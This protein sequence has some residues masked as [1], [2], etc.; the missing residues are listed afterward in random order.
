[1]KVY[2]ILTLILPIIQ[3]LHAEGY[4]SFGQYQRDEPE[5]CVECE[6]GLGL[7]KDVQAAVATM[8]KEK[9]VTK[10]EV[11]RAS[12]KLQGL[13]VVTQDV[14]DK[15]KSNEDCP[16]LANY[17]LVMP[18]SSAIDQKR[19][20]MTK[21]IPLINLDSMGVSTSYGSRTYYKGHDGQK[22]ILV[23]VI[24]KNDGKA[25]V[26]YYNFPHDQLTEKYKLPDLGSSYQREKKKGDF[27]LPTFNEKMEVFDGKVKASG[28]ISLKKAE[29]HI[30]TEVPALNGSGKVAVDKTGTPTLSLDHKKEFYTIHYDQVYHQ[31][32]T[33]D[34]S[35][36]TLTSPKSSSSVTYT[37]EGI[38]P[39]EVNFKQEMSFFESDIALTADVKMDKESPYYK[40]GVEIKRQG[41]RLISASVDSNDKF[42]VNIPTRFTI[43]QADDLV[44]KGDNS[45]S[46]K[47]NVFS[48]TVSAR[49]R[50]LINYSYQNKRNSD[51]NKQS[52]S[53]HVYQDR[54]STT[55]DVK[56]QRVTGAKLEDK[57]QNETTMWLTFQTK[58]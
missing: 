4:Y 37:R 54:S 6:K 56:V 39:D 1:M 27:E 49:D 20:Y 9:K 50:D 15:K 44:I 51:Y 5:T 30:S 57:E 29:A 12:D 45:F 42:S 19:L 34:K 22:E 21:D 33:K 10:E 11:I 38:N 55:F 46:S 3:S 24:T 58:F 26:R 8:I 40:R 2:F 25:E 13:I 16:Q 32:P 47:D 18:P 23:E 31:D 17:T 52:V 53:H 48:Y 7:A 41:E 43:S 35:S 14:L 28:G 36:V